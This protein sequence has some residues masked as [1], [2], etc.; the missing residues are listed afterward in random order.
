[1]SRRPAGNDAG[2]GRARGAGRRQE[3]AMDVSGKKRAL[4]SVSDKTGIV[5]FA[6]GWRSWATSSLSTGGTMRVWPRRASR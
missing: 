5:E 6:K 4:L 2:A 3:G 1:M